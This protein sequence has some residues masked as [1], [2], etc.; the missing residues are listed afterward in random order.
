VLRI[1]AIN[2]VI[3]PIAGTNPYTHSSKTIFT[4]VKRFSFIKSF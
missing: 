2:G 1:E 3:L 4:L